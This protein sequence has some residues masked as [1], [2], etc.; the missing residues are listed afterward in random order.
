MESMIQLCGWLHLIA[1]PRNRAEISLNDS[2][3]LAR[4][5]FT[6]QMS[7]GQSKLMM[8]VILVN[9]LIPMTIRTSQH[10]V[11][12]YALI[13]KWNQ[14]YLGTL[15]TVIRDTCC[16][17][18]WLPIS[19]EIYSH[20]LGRSY[21]NMSDLSISY[22][23]HRR[24]LCI[25]VLS[26]VSTMTCMSFSCFHRLEDFSLHLPFCFLRFEI[27]S[28]GI[29]SS[30]KADLDAIFSFFSSWRVWDFANVTVTVFSACLD[31]LA[32]SKQRSILS[33]LP[34]H[35]NATKANDLCSS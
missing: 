23:G 8:I 28:H 12:F 3:F 20:L 4:K 29:L 15:V 13:P 31:W 10:C 27:W 1:A 21:H 24:I 18:L 32:S 19:N 5:N 33:S 26:D 14:I 2:N 11:R 7:D 34:R 16:R 6:K 35:P 25:I 17:Y 22:F 30:R 9:I